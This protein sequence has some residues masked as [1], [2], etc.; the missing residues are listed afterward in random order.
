MV[1]TCGALSAQPNAIDS[2]F[3][4]YMDDDRFTVVYIS[5]K[6]LNLFG[7]I[8]LGDHEMDDDEA[9][10]FKKIAAGLQGLRILTTEENSEEF[11]KEALDKIQTTDYEILMTVKDN[12]GQN[13]NFYIKE[14]E[15]GKIGELFLIAGGPGEDF[16]LISFVGKLSLEDVTKFAKDIGN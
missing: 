14:T 3:Q 9:E 10:S 16:V 5:S 2:Y 13:F 7:E 6:L 11:Y 8:D 4:K 1:F 15:E 12:D